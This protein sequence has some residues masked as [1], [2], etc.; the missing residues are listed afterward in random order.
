MGQCSRTRPPPG[1]VSLRPFRKR[2]QERGRAL[3]Q[4]RVPRLGS[5]P[6]T[7]QWCAQ[8][9]AGQA[10]RVLHGLT[11]ANIVEGHHE[12]VFPAACGRPGGVIRV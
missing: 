10:A 9:A 11:V 1:A 2:D 8:E 3:K 5:L 12:G 4:E 7:S 6:V